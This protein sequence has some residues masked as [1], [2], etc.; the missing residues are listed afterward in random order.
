MW[1]AC[2]LP[3]HSGRGPA[4]DALPGGEHATVRTSA[5]RAYEGCLPSLA[6]GAGPC[7][8]LVSGFASTDGHCEGGWPANG[9]SY[10]QSRWN[11]SKQASIASCG[12]GIITTITTIIRT[13][14]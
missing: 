2:S 11:S 4:D 1:I 12:K 7:C 8:S 5:I 6:F 9:S 3:R 14:A 10:L 13:S